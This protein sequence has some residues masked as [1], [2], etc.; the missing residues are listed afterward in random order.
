MCVR[1]GWGGHSTSSL[2][3]KETVQHRDSGKKVQRHR[4]R[5]VVLFLTGVE[6]SGNKKHKEP[7]QV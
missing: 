3:N 5:S 2:P 6:K 4:S 7:Y 1:E